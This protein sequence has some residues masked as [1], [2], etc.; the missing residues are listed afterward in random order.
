MDHY[1]SVVDIIVSLINTSYDYL[2]E[3]TI[4]QILWICENL[5]T[6]AVPRLIE[7]F[8]ELLRCISP[9]LTDKKSLFLNQILV[10]IISK[11][12]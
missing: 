5:I 2:K 6:K 1:E 11:N 10:D 3:N 7:I 9:I 8:L 12:L 4:K